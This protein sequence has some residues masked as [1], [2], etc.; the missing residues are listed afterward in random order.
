M[1]S[2]DH[3]LKAVNTYWRDW[4]TE[5]GRRAILSITLPGQGVSTDSEILHTIPR[6]TS[7]LEIRSETK[8]F[9]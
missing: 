7:K 4:S 1:N 3:L 6:W 9:S 8:F 5:R 2:I